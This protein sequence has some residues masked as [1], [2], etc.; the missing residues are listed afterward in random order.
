[1][2]LAQML[3]LVRFSNQFTN[4]MRSLIAILRFH[5]CC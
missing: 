4:Q 1:M 2:T 3:D 5:A